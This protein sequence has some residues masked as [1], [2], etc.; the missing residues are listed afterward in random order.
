MNYRKPAKRTRT[1]GTE[2]RETEPPRTAAADETREPKSPR[3]ATDNEPC[4]TL[5]IKNRFQE[6]T[7]TIRNLS[8][9]VK[10]CYRLLKPVKNS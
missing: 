4:E 5:S 2:P 3:T 7:R 9:I 10:T 1:E 6:P 8:K